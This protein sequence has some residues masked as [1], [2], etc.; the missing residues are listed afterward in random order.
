MSITPGR[1][2]AFVR[3]TDTFLSLCTCHYPVLRKSAGA[4]K[5]LSDSSTSNRNITCTN[6]P[7]AAVRSSVTI[8]LY[9]NKCLQTEQ[10]KSVKSQQQQKNNRKKNMCCGIIY[11]DIL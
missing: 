3:K 6:P 10:R 2:V 1:L 11:I 7:S 9:C 4:S 8:F 5:M